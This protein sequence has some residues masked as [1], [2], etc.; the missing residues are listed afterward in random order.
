MARPTNANAE[1]TRLRIIEAASS[2][3]AEKGRAGASIREI[4]GAAQV[5]GAMI[6]HYLGGKEGLYQDCIQSLYAELA[7]GQAAFEAALASG[8]PLGQVVERTV[9]AAVAFSRQRRGLIRL[10]MRH[11]LDRGELD[12]ERRELVLLPF[13]ERATTLISMVSSQT[14]TQIRLGLQSLIFLTVRY[15]LCSEEELRQIVGD[16]ADSQAQLTEHLVNISVTTLGL[17]GAI[18]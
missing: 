4:A 12:P 15:A 3:F 5:N 16:G 1:A 14:A 9:A 8:G 17:E 7:T 10:I 6:S 11:V 2:L 18:S 13:L